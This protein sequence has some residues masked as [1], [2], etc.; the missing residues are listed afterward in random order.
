LAKPSF[1]V[2]AEGKVYAV[3]RAPDG[4]VVFGGEFSHVNGAPRA[5]IARLTP[6]GNLDDAWSPSSDG[7]VYALAV[8][9]DGAVFAGG[10]FS[11]IG[12]QQRPFLAKLDAGSGVADA[13][14]NPNAGQAVRALA[15]DG[16]DL[17]VGGVFSDIGGMEH[18]GLAKVS[19]S[20]P[21]TVDGSWAPAIDD[22]PNAFA[23]GNGYLFI[24]G[25]FDAVSGTSRYG[26]AKVSLATGALDPDWNPDSKSDSY[27]LLADDAGD[28]FVGRTIGEIGGAWHGGAVKLSALTGEVD[29][30]WNPAD[31]GVVTAL[32]S[33]GAGNIYL[34]G[35]FT[36]GGKSI[37][38]IV[39]V[40]M[41]GAASPDPDWT[42]PELSTESGNGVVVRAIVLSGSRVYIGGELDK[43]GV[44]TRLALVA[45][46]SNSGQPEPAVDIEVPGSVYAL[47]AQPDG[48]MIAGGDFLVVSAGDSRRHLLRVAPSGD[49]DPDWLVDTDGTVRCL[50][51][52]GDGAIYA[53]GRFTHVN[54]TMRYGIAKLVGTG[55][56][57]VDAAWD[58]ATGAFVDSGGVN[59]IAFGTDASMYAISTY[60]AAKLSRS[61]GIRD[62]AW[63][64][65]TNGPLYSIAAD[66]DN[67]VYLGGL[68]SSIANPPVTR[69]FLA[70]V[71]GDGTGVPDPDWNPN[72]DNIVTALVFRNDQLL[73]GGSFSSIGGQARF[74]LAQVSTTGAG[75]V[76]DW[77]PASPIGLDHVASIAAFNGSLYVAGSYFY[78]EDHGAVVKLSEETGLV[79]G[80]WNPLA[81]ATVHAVAASAGGV[82]FTG[83]SFQTIA[84]TERMAL[85]AFPPIAPDPIFADGFQ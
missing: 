44:A 8:G 29:E 39:K 12:G 79:D 78:I 54:G 41:G 84:G 56:S 42:N 33:D 82:I 38:T 51:M 58:A 80:S 85:A 13:S 47:M 36:P 48:G 43:V 74:E 24:A 20:D 53:G 45:L 66:A 65:F 62:V 30:T 1:E 70:K 25:G 76:G 17:Y 50:A 11:A 9:A 83:G 7:P 2:F 67:G 23:V 81:D 10:L 75:S 46:Q 71:S 27:A 3:A 6:D 64:P 26:L 73:A 40:S 61:S 14:W 5:N 77:A 49:L 72:P 4:S 21:A 19:T 55:N 59:G 35:E 32:A 52:D 28:V 18:H 34:G 31:A 22:A 63:N 57:M 69:H 60:L 68:F 15:I 16:T 37:S